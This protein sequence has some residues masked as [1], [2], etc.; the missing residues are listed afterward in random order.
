MRE[1]DMHLS[2]G[3]V[4]DL[5]GRILDELEQLTVSVATLGYPSLTVGMLQNQSWVHAVRLHDARRLFGDLL[6]DG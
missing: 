6:D 4:R 2:T 3:R 5:V 1:N